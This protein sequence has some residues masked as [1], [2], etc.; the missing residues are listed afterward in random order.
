MYNWITVSIF[1]LLVFA[2]GMFIVN[3][4]RTLFRPV[5]TGE[6]P[7]E[8]HEHGWR[9]LVD[10]ERNLRKRRFLIGYLVVAGLMYFGVLLKEPINIVYAHYNPAPT[11]TQTWT[12]PKEYYR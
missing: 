5:R 12:V 11:P 9:G 7:V 10:D 4:R 3:R 6:S 1:L 8:E 2:L